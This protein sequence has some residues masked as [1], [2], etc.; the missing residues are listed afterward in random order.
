MDVC[1]RWVTEEVT[2]LAALPVPGADLATHA[3]NFGVK[4]LPVLDTSSSNS[5]AL[6]SNSPVPRDAHIVAHAQGSQHSLFQ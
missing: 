2:S 5:A 3:D 4:G 1:S 6:G